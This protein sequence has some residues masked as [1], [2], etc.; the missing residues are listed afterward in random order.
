MSTQP[1]NSLVFNTWFNIR[2]PASAANTDSKDNNIPAIVGLASFCAKICSVY[3]TQEEK[4][5]VYSS[6]IYA[7]NIEAIVGL[8]ITIIGITVA[9]PPINSCPQDNLTGST[10]VLK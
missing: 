10:R 4:I 5:P 3:A 2:Y 6:G 9:N 8:S 1:I 7:A